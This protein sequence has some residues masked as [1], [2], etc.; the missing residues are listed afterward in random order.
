MKLMFL[1]T[2]LRSLSHLSRLMA[3]SGARTK[4]LLLHIGQKPP[5]HLPTV[6]MQLFESRRGGW[7]LGCP[8]A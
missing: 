1:A 8:P 2:L 3:V 7:C 5:L 6:G 4:K